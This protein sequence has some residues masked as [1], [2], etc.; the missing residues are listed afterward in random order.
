MNKYG[1]VVGKF[2]PLHRG[3]VDLI[4]TASSMCEKLIVIVSH[5]DIRDYKLYEDSSMKKPLTAKDKL[6]IVQKTFQMQKEVIIPILVDETNCSEYPNGWEEW[7]NLVK[8]NISEDK[9]IGKDFNWEDVVFYGSEMQDVINYKKHFK[10]KDVYIFDSYR[11]TNNI[12][13]S[14]VRN[15]VSKYW[16]YLPRA[17]KELLCPVIVLAGGESSGKT[18]LTD[19]LGNYFS[20]TTV[21]EYGRNFTELELGGDES[22]LQYSDYQTI[23][24]GHYQ[25]IRFA[26][27]NAN[28][29]T[30]SDTDYIATQA[31]CI[32]Y[33][34]KEHPSVEDKILNDKFDLV[35]LLNNNTKWIDDGMR[36][37]K[38]DN[39]RQKFQMLLKELYKR[40]NIPYVEI[41]T[42]DYLLRYEICKKVIHTY[43]FSD[44]KLSIEHL[45]SLINDMEN[46][47]I[48]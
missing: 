41:S 22:A 7:S 12:S 6:K 20:T 42:N 32:T 10:C 34:G 23:C 17:S 33:E 35:I 39:R 38:D 21:W 47:R 13:A 25:D 26:K 29:F 9:R 15:N 14:K 48:N 11:L 1:V 45:Q 40:Y 4:Q 30:I 5:H 44:K 43:I 36:S 16:D 46:N 8:N 31:F 19:K 28:K 24:N 18:F 37:I 2:Y 27:R 3:H